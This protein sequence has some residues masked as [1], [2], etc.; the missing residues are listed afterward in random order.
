MI[1]AA[2]TFNV[3]NEKLSNVRVAVGGVGKH[4]VRLTELEKKL[5]SHKLLARSEIEDTVKNIVAPVED[6]RGGFQFKK[7]IAGVLISDCIHS[8]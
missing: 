1:T 7:Y 6:I 4:V 3:Q 8:A 5:E 2:V